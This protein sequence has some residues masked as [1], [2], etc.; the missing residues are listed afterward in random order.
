MGQKGNLQSLRT[1]KSLNLS[2]KNEKLVIYSLVF[3]DKFKKM[4]DIRG[5]LVLN[6]TLNYMSNTIIYKLKLYYKTNR[7][8]NYRRKIHNKKSIDER[9]ELSKNNLIFLKFLSKSFSFFKKSVFLL[10]FENLNKDINKKITTFLF[11]KFKKRGYNLFSRRFNFFIDFIKL[12]SLVYENKI[13]AKNFI[14]TIGQVFKMLPKKQHSSFLFFIKN[15]IHIF[16][17]ELPCILDEKNSRIKGI[18]IRIS[19]R[20][21]GKPRSSSTFVQEGVVPTQSI[22]KDVDFSS[23]H[24]YTMYGAFGIKSWIYR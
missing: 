7:T 19:G 13:P 1:K 3:L 22:D 24:V 21:K 17:V 14:Y 12:L 23:L 4:L 15:I 20:L 16:I 5:V 6:N 8:S 2:K 9:E 11:Q 10:N 18:K